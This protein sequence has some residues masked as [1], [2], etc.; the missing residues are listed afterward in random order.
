MSECFSL[1]GF[2]FKKRAKA[3]DWSKRWFVLNEKSGK[4]GCIGIKLLIYSFS[5]F[6]GGS[7]I[8]LQLG[9]TKKQEEKHFRGVINL[10]VIIFSVILVIAIWSFRFMC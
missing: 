3:N 1:K 10:E 4:V 9:Y 6:D 5:P 2:L 7:K 8:Y